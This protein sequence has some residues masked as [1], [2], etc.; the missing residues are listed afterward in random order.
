MKTIKLLLN[1]FLDNFGFS[2]IQEFKTSMFHK[3]YFL[4]SI[5]FA[6]ILSCIEYCFGLSWLTILGVLVTLLMELITGITASII[7]GKKIESRKFSR[8]GLKAFVWFGFL[9]VINT[10]ILQYKDS[11]N[12]LHFFWSSAHSLFASY[13]AIEYFISIDEN[14]TRITGKRYGVM[15]VLRDRFKKLIGMKDGQDN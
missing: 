7:E 5:P 10:F 2:N 1:H 11:A 6:G 13:M 3:E 12:Y 14:I 4:L 15:V 8:F 9:F